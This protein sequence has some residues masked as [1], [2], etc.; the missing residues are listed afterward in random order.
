MDSEAEEPP[1]LSVD[2]D[3]SAKYKGAFCE[4]KIRKVVRSVKCKVIF[5][6]GWGSATIPDDQIRGTLRIGS[7]VEAKHPEKKEFAEA[8]ITKIQDC[9]QYTVVFDDGDITTLR[10]TALCLKSGRHFAESDTLDQLPLTHPE[11]FSNPVIGGRRGRRRLDENSEDEELLLITGAELE[12][13][14][15]EHIGRVVCVEGSEKKKQK[16]NWFPGLVVAPTAQD[17]VPIH[18]KEEYLVRSFK[19]GRYYT[20]PKKEANEFTREVGAR[21]EHPTLK[22]AVDK[23]LLYLD[24]DEL[25]PHWD[26][27]LLLYG[28]GDVTS[29]DNDAGLD[30]EV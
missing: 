10:R 27:D 14:R 9:S 28:L 5:K 12:D 26:R 22:A 3:V 16:D 1:Y 15:E 30:Y 18:V 7:V 19:D 21:A 6:Q 20:V 17:N 24:S 11:H 8:T 29:T 13:E 25:P 2:T 4:A 23:A